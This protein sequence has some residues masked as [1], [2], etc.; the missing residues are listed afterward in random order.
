M[1]PHGREQAGGGGREPLKLGHRTRDRP[2]LARAHAR[3]EEGEIG[4]VLRFRGAAR[5]G[6]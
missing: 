6:R 2:A 5:H 3:N 4:K 1:G